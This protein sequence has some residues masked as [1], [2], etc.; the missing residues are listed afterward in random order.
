MSD[1]KNACATKCPGSHV[2]NVICMIEK[3]LKIVVFAGLA[4]VLFDIHGMLKAQKEYANAVTAAVSAQ[5]ANMSTSD[6]S[7]AMPAASSKSK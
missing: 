2:G 6:N 7:M 1:D 5:S 4:M 3:I